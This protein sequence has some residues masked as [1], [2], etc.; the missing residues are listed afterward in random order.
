MQMVEFV[1]IFYRT[2]GVQR[3]MFLQYSRQ[4]RYLLVKSA[5][6]Y[7]SSYERYL[8]IS[9]LDYTWTQT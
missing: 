5:I 9:K 4:Y 7:F 6:S 2:D 1:W 8:I 3:M